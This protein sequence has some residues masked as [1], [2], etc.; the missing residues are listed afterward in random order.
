MA[1]SGMKLLFFYA[2]V[3]ER[4]RVF[5]LFLL[6]SYRNFCNCFFGAENRKILPSAIPVFALSRLLASPGEGSEELP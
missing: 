1:F 5:M 6:R 2:S 4:R 3:E